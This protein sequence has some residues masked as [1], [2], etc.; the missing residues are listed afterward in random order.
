MRGT[1]MPTTPEAIRSKF[2][3]HHGAWIVRA[4]I[5][6]GH[7]APGVQS[8]AALLVRVENGAGRPEVRVR[9]FS[10]GGWRKRAEIT[11]GLS[12][13]GEH[14]PAHSPITYSP[15]RSRYGYRKIHK[16]IKSQIWRKDPTRSQLVVDPRV[17]VRWE[18]APRP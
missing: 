13:D 6:H 7:D 10:D 9:C 5:E 8:R 16:W 18:S 3:T 15:V 14:I 12:I 2:L 1:D 4:E 17:P 11:A